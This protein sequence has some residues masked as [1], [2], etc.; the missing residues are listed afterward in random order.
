MLQC[1]SIFTCSLS[2]FAWFFLFLFF[3]INVWSPRLR[4]SMT[5][6]WEDSS[7]R[8]FTMPRP[9]MTTPR[10]LLMPTSSIVPHPSKNADNFHLRHHSGAQSVIASRHPTL[11]PVIVFHLNSSCGW[12][13][14]LKR[15]DPSLSFAGRFAPPRQLGHKRPSCQG[16]PPQTNLHVHS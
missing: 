7:I 13:L 16:D 14:N 2:P 5:Q 11:G 8:P 12:T 9:P 4:S 1:I 3:G 6:T 15:V 10:S